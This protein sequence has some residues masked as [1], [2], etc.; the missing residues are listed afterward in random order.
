MD[1]RSIL[2][3]PDD[4]TPLDASLRSEGGRQYRQTD[5]GIYILDSQRPVPADKV[6]HCR[7]FRDWDALV[8]K[9]MRYYTES[10]TIAG[11]LAQ[12]SYRDI[13]RFQQR[14]RGTWLLDIGC[15]DGAQI[16]RLGD[17]HGYVGLDRNMHRLRVLKQR[18][19]EAVAIYGDAARLPIQSGTI[20]YVF[21]SNAFEHLW[22]L[23][24]A[25]ME[26]HRVTTPDSELQIV[27][28]TEGGLWNL[29]RRLISRRHYRRQHPDIDF[30]LISHLEHCNQAGQ[31]V[32]T[33]QTFFR[34]RVRYLPMRVPTI[35]LN[36][37]LSVALRRRND[38]SLHELE[39]AT[40]G[41]NGTGS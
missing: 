10:A 25:V 27:F 26:L 2:R 16:A 12:F 32:R 38:L 36:V 34:S 6:Y 35:Y 9:R 39:P 19:P 20:D 30:D 17:C 5:E 4:G 21:S 40:V 11:R 7:Q 18:Y 24:D 29:G 31:I 8:E 3:S 1:I 23:K 22:Y 37:L 28:P 33:L 13:G 15:G 41:E 14:R